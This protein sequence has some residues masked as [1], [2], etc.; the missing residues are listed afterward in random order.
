MIELEYL[1]N[2][3]GVVIALEPTEVYRLDKETFL[4]CITKYPYLFKT[5]W[6]IAQGNGEMVAYFRRRYDDL[7]ESVQKQKGIYA[8]FNF[9][10]ENIDT[11]PEESTPL[12]IDSDQK[13]ASP[14]SL[15][16]TES[17]SDPEFKRK[18]SKRRES[19]SSVRFDLRQFGSGT[20]DSTQLG[21]EAADSAR[22]RLGTFDSEQ[23]GSGAVDSEQ[24][25]SGAVNSEQSGSGAFNSEESGSGTDKSAQLSSQT[26]DSAKLESGTVR[27]IQSETET[28]ESKRLLTDS[29]E[30]QTNLNRRND[31]VELPSSFS[32]SENTSEEQTKEQSKKKSK[33]QRN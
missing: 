8:L 6:D 24:S 26:V 13:V 19:I 17:I 10:D 29:S 11:F 5:F 15:S 25:G 32:T 33:N 20:V 7:A 30:T 22:L 21:S 23:S 9:S 3:Y 18:K 12:K 4:N 16:P 2:A 27:S 1:S 28:I 31:S 14:P